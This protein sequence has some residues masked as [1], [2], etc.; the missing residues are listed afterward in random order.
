[1]KQVEY[2]EGKGLVV[3][4]R[5]TKK[6]VDP[7]SG[8]EFEL[9]NSIIRNP[10][11]SIVYEIKDVEVPKFW[12]QVA[13][14]ILAQKYFRKA[15]VPNTGTEKSVKQVIDRMTK[16]WRYWGERY[17]YFASEDDAQAFEDELKHMLVYQMAA[18]NSPQ[19]FNTGLALSYGITG[20]PQ[21]H[22]YVDPETAE[23]TLAPDAYTHSQAHA[24]F[25]QTVNDD[26]VSEGGIFDLVLREARVFKY[27]SGT[28]SNFSNLR[29]KGEKLSGGGSSSGLMSF[30]KIF[31]RA[32][33]AIKCLHEDTELVTT[34]GVT[35]IKDMKKGD[36]VITRDGFK[37]VTNI[38][39]NGVQDLVTVRTGLGFEI[40]CTQEHRFWVRTSSGEEL[41]K[42]AKEI[43]P[44]DF[45]CIDFS[46]YDGFGYKELKPISLE[47]HNEKEVKF[48]RYLN[49]KFAEWLGWIFGDGNV[50][51]RKYAAYI[52]VQIGDSET[53]LVDKYTTLVKDLFGV[54]VFLNRRHDK[55]DKSL[56]LRIA[57]RPLIR[58]LREN[59]ICKGKARDISIPKYIKE[60]PSSVR[61]AFL[62]GFFEADGTIERGLYPACSSISKDMIQDIQLLLQSI[63]VISKSFVSEHRENSFGKNPL[64]RIIVTSSFG[65]REFSNRVSFISNR[66]KSIVAKA[67]NF[68]QDR[69][70]EQQWVLPYFE[71]QFEE[72]YANLPANLNKLGVRRSTSKYFRETTGKTNFNRFRANILIKMFPDL[73][74]TFIAKL[75]KSNIYY[76]TVT[77][78]KA[79][80]GR[81]YDIEVNNGHQYL[82]NG[83]ITHNSGGTTRRAAKMVII[84]A[85]HPEIE[86]F[87]NWKVNEEQKVADLYTGSRINQKY[88]NKIMKVAH[89]QKT[90]DW[91]QNKEL[92][93]VILSALTRNVPFTYITRAL[94]LVE[95]GKANIDFP[96]YD[97]H[98]EGEAYITV[99]GQNSNN[100]IRIPN[101]FMDAAKNNDKWPLIGRTTGSVIKTLDARDLWNKIS[102]AAW[103][104]A[105]PGIQFDD[106][107]NE[108]HTC[109]TDGKIYATN[110]CSEYIFLND[111]ACNL[112]SIN[113]MK[114]LDEETGRFDV[115]TFKHATRLWTVVLEISV[116]M[117]GFPSKE[118]ATKSYEFRTLGLGYANL[119]TLLMVLGIPYDSE[120][121]RAIAGTL[122]AILC[123][124]S[125]ATSAEM[126]KYFGSFPAYNRNAEH[127]LR[128][129]RNHRRATYNVP[130]E[131][132][133]GLTV[134]P[135]AINPKYCPDYLLQAARECWDRALSEGTK[136]GYRNAQVTVIAPTGTIGLVMSCDTTGIEPDFAT[137]KFK[138]L[139]GGGYF[140][141][142]N[143][144]V[145]K[146]LKRFG[147]STQQIK[148]IE[149]YC[150]GHGTLA[151]C[152]HINPETLRAKGFT[153][154]KLQNIESL[155]SNTFDLKFVF[156]KLTLGEEFCI[157]K[158]GIKKEQLDNPEF[159]LL[160]TLG[161]T[162]EQIRIA[163]D[164]V[165][166]TMTIE[167][168]PHLRQEHYA[169]FDCA[170]RCGKY[171]KRFIDYMAHV[172]MMGA[173]QPFISGGIS[174]T[175]NMPNEATVD[176]VK[177][178]YDQSY[179][180]MV[181]CI[182][183]YRD[184]SKLSQPL[185]SQAEDENK[186]LSLVGN[187]EEVDETVGDK[188]L[189]EVIVRGMRKKLP[190]KR[191]GFVQEARVGGQK[192]FVR[193]GEYPDGALGEV[194]IDTYKEGAGYRSLLNCFA[195]AVSKGLQYGVPLDEFV[196]TFTFTR[197]EPSGVVSG[198]SNVKQAS[199]I[200]DY[201]FRVL[202]YEYLHRTDLVHVIDEDK[203]ELTVK[204][205]VPPEKDEMQKIKVEI[206]KIVDSET[207]KILEAKTQGF[208][209][210][211][212]GKCGSMRVKQ[213]GACAVCVD[214]GETTGCS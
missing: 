59:G 168:S 176:D 82:V 138:K 102:Y 97:T 149:E 178:V 55:K 158:L 143:D 86:S 9:R 199:S 133:E 112:A 174:K 106:H 160:A 173:V 70:F 122:T 90:T 184:G 64:H 43:T 135:V 35:K 179:N 10:D 116:L 108:W 65:I 169:I 30:L 8:I 78:E 60:S 193:T 44:Y 21:G 26:L 81:V 161:F 18:P 63:G 162:S 196:E 107:I 155:L 79:S 192:I 198:H 48:P 172:K 177:N 195:I 200:I 115:E 31:D 212:C 119:G 191:A 144:A 27:G 56:S 141:I 150:R 126:S 89:E 182:A 61:A 5:F 34:R 117:A 146:A 188:Q 134:K 153:D 186:L 114:F 69:P 54:H 147:Y 213:N 131:E 4:R 104:C 148:E 100:S 170:N 77:V 98:Y 51:D 197:F 207:G 204:P 50:T 210:E 214:C 46:G 145:S 103:S 211:Q 142:V 20:T 12:T 22:W 87:I 72:M 152:P 202:G 71:E 128:V 129:I 190:S 53:D 157:N 11:G 166:G 95:Q 109:P 140:K 205:T 39:D 57:S 66:K 137:V 80:E 187:V 1:M 165:C 73:E 67:L 76:D 14:D 52:G 124:E 28:G 47:H 132:Y 36:F 88:L 180:L 17:G 83:V 93:R 7:Y 29:G 85:D 159:D 110:P 37:E 49:E 201:V 84:D 99:S 194:F 42:E 16:C 105:D 113:L 96:V 164:Y 2:A 68:L 127:M 25:I 19:W 175:I 120:E 118:I 208:T 136:Y 24:C 154:E 75:A 123:G 171:G 139:A 111:T 181:K 58:F 74:D 45:V 23:T 156:N 101:R 167:G 203:K 209:G 130:T 163:N 125:Y 185:N 94:Q 91:K 32:A 13:T 62:R 151:N 92:R 40:N 121:A 3:T 41:W 189:Q 183:L 38:F 15:G 6:G 206:P 33:G